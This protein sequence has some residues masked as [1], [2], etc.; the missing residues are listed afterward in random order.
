V[1]QVVALEKEFDGRC[2]VVADDHHR[3]I[4]PRTHLQELAHPRGD[5][6]RPRSL[7]LP[8]DRRPLHLF[9][10]GGRVRSREPQ[11]HQMLDRTRDPLRH[12]HPSRVHRLTS[13]IRD[14]RPTPHREQITNGPIEV[15]QEGIR[16]HHVQNLSVG[17]THRYRV[18]T[19]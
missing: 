6:R 4:R 16:I 14:R 15:Q 5:R 1:G 13:P 17:A 10:Y 8:V 2:R 18:G 9:Q 3:P 12:Y 11:H 7:D 19:F